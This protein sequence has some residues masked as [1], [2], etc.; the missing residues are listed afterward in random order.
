VPAFQKEWDAA[1]ETMRYLN[2]A[3]GTAQ[4]RLAEIG[5]DSATI[6]FYETVLT[7]E[8]YREIAEYCRKYSPKLSFLSFAPECFA[9]PAE[10]VDRIMEW[11]RETGI[12][13][14]IY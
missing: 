14:G 10:E 7:L 3:G 1:Q 13:W 2:P 8:Q 5:E 9:E 6:H 4:W 12:Y 11:I